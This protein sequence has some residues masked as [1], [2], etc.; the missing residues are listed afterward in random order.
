M[1]S[2]SAARASSMMRSK[3]RRIAASVNGPGL[4][5]SAFSSTSFSRAGLRDAESD[6]DGKL[7]DGA[8]AADES[9]EI[10][11]QGILNAGDAS[12]GNEI[13]KTGGAR[14]D[15]PEAIVRGSRRTEEDGVEWMS[16]EKAA[17]VFGFF[18]REIDG[19]NAIC[20]GNRC[21]GCEFLEAHL[22]DGIVIAEQDE[23]DLVGRRAQ[24]AD[25]ADQIDD[26]GEGR[27][28]FQGTFGAALDGRSIGERV[29]EGNAEV[30]DGGSGFAKGPD[31]FQ[32]GVERGVACGDVG[33]DAEFA[34]CAQFSEAFGDAGRVGGNYGHSV[35]KERLEQAGVSVHVLVA[36]AGEVEDDQV[37]FAHF[38]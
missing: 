10:V 35:W 16:G 13:E 25:A 12:A 24:L 11:G 17:I 32:R 7:C 26:P 19:E 28:G 30:D 18:E 20:A 4:L 5:R 22:Q 36:T 2:R 31:K 34:G 15:L 33:D 37:A 8:G 29:A 14:G 21:G 38:G 1:A 9:G 27:A 6:G 3:R 23:R